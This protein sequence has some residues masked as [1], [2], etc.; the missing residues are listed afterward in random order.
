MNTNVNAL[1]DLWVPIVKSD[2]IHVRLI[3][4]ALEAFAI[5]KDMT[6]PVT[7]PHVDKAKH[8]NLKEMMFAVVTHV[9]TVGPAKK[10][11]TETPSS[12]FV[13]PDTVEITARHLLIHVDLT[14]VCL[15]A[16]A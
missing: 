12:A 11:P 7:V 5:S 1:T 14:H 15:A 10:V 6:S 8:V 2:K 3:P 9:K 16:Y 13:D 4:V